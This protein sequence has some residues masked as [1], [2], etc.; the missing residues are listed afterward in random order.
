[1]NLLSKMYGGSLRPHDPRRFLIEAMVAAIQA[2]G[3]VAQEELDVLEASLQEHEMFAGLKPDIT[4][5][6]IEMAG[7]SIAFAG[8][9]MRRV[10]YMAKNLPSRSHRMAAYAVA[11]EIVLADDPVPAEA[12][13]EYLDYLKTWFLLG[14][15]EAKAI[16]QAAGRRRGM[17]EVEERTRQMQGV[18]PYNIEGMAL[19]ACADGNVS[20]AERQ[21]LRGVLRNI[22]DTAVL[23]DNELEDLI[24]DAFRKVEGKDGDREIVRI[25]NGMETPSD[26]Y[27]AAVYMMILALAD[28][29]RDWRQVWLLG[30]AQEALKLTDD[31][32]DRAWSTAKL[33]PIVK[34]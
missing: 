33:F 29:H 25:A 16:F 31:D 6:L 17:A 22:G 34:H 30:S 12:E 32:M 20:S 21:A 2:D 3:V 13:Q 9:V 10:P 1:M 14:E 11:C 24:E 15:E 8:G 23:G 5:V 18:M 4:R 7:D 26:R 28:G 27:W 19:M